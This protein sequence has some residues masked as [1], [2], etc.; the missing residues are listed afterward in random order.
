[1]RKKNWVDGSAFQRV[2]KEMPK[3]NWIEG[4]DFQKVCQEMQKKNW[5]DGSDFQRVCKEVR[6]K[7]RYLLV[8]QEKGF[9]LRVDCCLKAWKWE[10][11]RFIF[12]LCCG[13][14]VGQ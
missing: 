6:K 14:T 3:K 10:Q 2:C 13:Y 1:M 7:N 12:P 11:Q 8:F 9:V 4:S 5:V